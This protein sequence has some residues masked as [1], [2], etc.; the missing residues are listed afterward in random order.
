ARN[1]RAPGMIVVAAGAVEHARIVD[2]VQTRF[3]AFSGPAAPAP[4]KARFQGGTLVEPRDLEQVHIALALE[5]LPT[6]DA[7]LYSLQVFTAV[8]GGG[9]SSR[10]FQEVREAR[11]LCYAINAFH[12][13]YRDTG[14]FG[15]YAGTDQA[16]APELM[17]VVISE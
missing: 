9:M 3:A 10:L 14:L 2:E 5:G 11:G 7:E 12:M 4:E 13:P 1:Y 17:R 16:D 15:L 6:G 8:R